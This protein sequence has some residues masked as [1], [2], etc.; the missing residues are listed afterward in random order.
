MTG[1]SFVLELVPRGGK[2]EFEPHPHNEILVPY[3]KISDDRQ[4]YMRVPLG[5]EGWD[6]IS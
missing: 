3:P 2:N 6:G 1:T 5:S 4:F